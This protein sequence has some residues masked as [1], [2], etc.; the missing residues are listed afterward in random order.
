MES[1]I[2]YTSSKLPPPSPQFQVTPQIPKTVKNV[3][4]L[5]EIR[6]KVLPQGWIYSK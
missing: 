6:H 3:I 4:K 2:G 1:Q 5:Y